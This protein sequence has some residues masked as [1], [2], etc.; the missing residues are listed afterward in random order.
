M[1]PKRF[2]IQH[3]S[4]F[5]RHCLW[6]DRLSQ[7]VVAL[8]LTFAASNLVLPAESVSNAFA[9]PAKTKKVVAKKAVAK[10]PAK[11]TPAVSGALG[12]GIA[13]YNRGLVEQAIPH[14]QR[15]ASQTPGQEAPALWLARAYGKQGMQAEAKNA[16]A[17]VLS[18]NSNNPEALTT[19]GELYTWDTSTRAKGIEMLERSYNQT[20]DVTTGKKLSEALL[21]IG[22]YD[23]AYSIGQQIS[24]RASNDKKWLSSY[25]QILAMSG[26]GNEAIDVYENQ[27]NIT[28]S[29][30]LAQIQAYATALFKAG[31]S[32]RA[33]QVYQSIK[34]YAVNLAPGQ[35]VEIKKSLGALAF[36]LGMYNES[37]EMDNSLPEPER[38]DKNI[39]LRVARALIRGGRSPEAVDELYRLYNQGKL[40]SSEKIEFADFLQREELEKGALPEPGLVDNLFKKAI[41]DDPSNVDAA[42]RLAQHNRYLPGAS[43]E[44]TDKYYQ[45]AW[46]LSEQYAPDKAPAVKREYLEFLKTNKADLAKAEFR[47]KGWMQVKPNDPEIMG[48]Y[49]EFLSYQDN[50]RLDSIRMYLSL[51]KADP[52]NADEW[53]MELDKVLG[54][55]KATTELIPLYQEIINT[56]PQDKSIYHSIARAYAANPDYYAEALD[57]YT[58]ML[59][60]F[61]G[62]PVIRKEWISLLMSNPKHRDE[63]IATL[64]QYSQQVPSDLDAQVALGQ[65][66]S[67]KREYGRSLDVLDNVLSKDPDH[68]DAAVAKG[69]TLMWSGRKLQAKHYL[70]EVWQKY[71]DDT[72]V[73]IAL[74]QANKFL[75]RYDEAFE[76]MKRIRPQL[77]ESAKSKSNAEVKPAVI[78]CAY[79]KPAQA[80]DF[81]KVVWDSPVVPTIQIAYA[82]V[83][84]MGSDAGSSMQP[85]VPVSNQR[86]VAPNAYRPLVPTAPLANPQRQVSQQ[87]VR[88]QYS[89]PYQ[90]PVNY[91]QG[92]QYNNAQ[93][94]EDNT[95][96]VPLE[97]LTPEEQERANLQ[98][99]VDALDSAIDSL[100]ALQASSTRQL[101]QLQQ[102]IVSSKDKLTA[103]V[104]VMDV[105]SDSTASSVMQEQME[106]YAM[107]SSLG[108]DT[109][110]LL[111]GM[112]RFRNSD[113]VQMERGLQND[114][115]PM[116]RAGFSFDTKTGEG[117]T[118][119]LSSYGFPNQVAISLSPQYRARF[120]VNPYKYYIPGASA[121]SPKSTWSQE[122]TWGLTAKLTDRLTFD[123]DMAIT[124]FNQSDSNN[125]TYDANLAYDIN[126]SWRVKLG[127]RRVP[128][129]NSLLSIAGLQPSQGAWAN[130]L[131][132]QSRETGVYGEVNWNPTANWD[133][134]LGYEWAFVDGEHVPTNY[135]N[136]AFFSPGYTWHYA[137]NHKVRIGLESLF[138]NYSKNTN[139]GYFDTVGGS[140]VPMAGLNPPV[141]SADG[142]DF[143]GYFSPHWFFQNAGRLDFRGNFFNKILE[144]KLGGSLGVQTFNEGHGITPSQKTALTGAA[145]LNLIG[146][147]TDWFALYG[148]GEYLKAG[149][150]FTRWR[151]GGGVIVRPK[152]DFLSPVFNR[153][154]V[155]SLEETNSTSKR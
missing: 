112:G 30:D 154:A 56:F 110:P 37:V 119:R 134:N 97:E 47:F 24:D 27:L 148:F 41:Q 144:Y 59:K 121:R 145:D 125:I 64:E 88:M 39:R 80:I 117:T 16:Y 45:Q 99:D 129:F 35:G 143:G 104:S 75:G 84:E 33:E 3:V 8:L 82:P 103:Q 155:P 61:P 20:G 38:S 91:S 48:A 101:N 1:S 107:F 96:Q 13:L 116:I 12:Q 58:R 15:A 65:L 109:N 113:L 57:A 60:K 77:Q 149:S 122:Y 83:P 9:A 31:Q 72:D 90:Q 6:M 136:Q 40:N 26:H 63:A 141:A 25:A 87:P 46:Q 126:D 49:A 86:Q 131:V 23:T 147:V 94:E 108:Y 55:H 130:T 68:K 135:K 153:S 11:S 138:M 36:D 51:A 73:G 7:S 132:G 4:S 78:L 115:R 52:Q 137:D 118:S 146:N 79:N 70:L 81:G 21:W 74:A 139:V 18:I 67:Y 111:S 29:R 28:Q 151:F 95:A 50:R 62:D 32:A 19:L 14:F 93:Y 124:Q 71:P 140:R 123:G 43:F 152:V 133:V 22:Y 92:V 17:H 85:L 54:W 69:Y 98:S 5:S 100:N 34:P 42:L 2:G 102:S 150:V 10:A 106:Q 66:Y 127:S 114:L 120:G 44:E 89:T 105:N 53:K 142:Y 76:V 128:Q